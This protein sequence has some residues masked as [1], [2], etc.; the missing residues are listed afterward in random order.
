[1][2]RGKPFH[3][4]PPGARRALLEG[5]RPSICLRSLQKSQTLSQKVGKRPEL[6]LPTLSNFQPGPPLA[7]PKGRRGGRKGAHWCSPGW[8]TGPAQ[9]GEKARVWGWALGD[10]LVFALWGWITEGA[11]EQ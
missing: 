6:T 8:S 5:G 2:H 1:M 11:T 3:P 7:E 4:R 10:S 9:G